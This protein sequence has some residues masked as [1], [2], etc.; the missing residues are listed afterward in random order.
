MNGSACGHAIPERFLENLIEGVYRFE[1]TVNPCT[2]DGSSR[3]LRMVRVAAGRSPLSG[4]TPAL[5]ACS[6]E[7]GT[8]TTCPS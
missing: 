7:Q 2:G 6:P 4:G 8:P 3:H 5:L 1:C